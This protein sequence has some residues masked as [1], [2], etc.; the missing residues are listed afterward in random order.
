MPEFIY[1]LQLNRPDILVAGP[2]T[3]EAVVLE[4]HGRYLAELAQQGTVQLAGRTQ[5]TSPETFGIVLLEANSEAEALLIMQQDP[6]VKHQVMKA[7]LW[8]F[9]TAFKSASHNK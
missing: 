3:E 1:R 9:K 2:T 4:E 7:Q 6:A 8:P 5:D